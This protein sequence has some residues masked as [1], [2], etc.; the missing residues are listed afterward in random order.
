M[1]IIYSII[2]SF[3]FVP[4][5]LYTLILQFSIPK[6]TNQSQCITSVSVI[7]VCNN[8]E[9]TI[10]RK[11][12]NIVE[13][14][15]HLTSQYEV[16]VISDGSID[17]TNSLL[18]RLSKEFNINCFYFPQRKGKVFALNH[19]ISKSAYPII[20][21]SDSR[22][23]I[24]DKSFCNLT[25]HFVDPNVGAVSSI[26]I[27]AGQKSVIRAIINKM[28]I[29]ESK[30]GSTIGVYGGL[31]DIRRDCVSILDEKTILDDLL[32]SL[33]V[34]NK[35]KRVIVEPSAIIYDVSFAQYYPSIRIKRIING[36]FQIARNNWVII[37]KLSVKNI[38]FLYVQKYSKL[39][40]PILFLIMTLIAF[41]SKYIF[42][43]HLLIFV[44]LAMIFALL[45]MKELIYIVKFLGIY[46]ISIFSK[47]KKDIHLW[48]KSIRLPTKS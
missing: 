37:K 47:N 23:K 6:V 32:I 38:L 34:L 21:F 12:L 5:V 1:E 16:I 11:I 13:E 8:E 28:K 4:L 29:L 22:Q 43:L 39:S 45:S 7:L 25:K 35:G 30:Q 10:K 33:L 41:T 44:L 31:Y 20:I 18:R 36:L 2:F 17:G 42:Y 48:E 19:G 27:N 46:V 40:I 15:E 26:L 14:C 24:I 3:L 9:E